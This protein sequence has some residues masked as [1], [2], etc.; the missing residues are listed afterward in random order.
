MDTIP[1]PRVDVQPDPATLST[2]VAGELLSRIADAQAAGG[3]PAVCLTGGTIAEEVHREIGRLGAASAVDWS[4]VDFWW[5]DERYVDLDSSDRNSRGAREAFLEPLGVPASRIHEMPT[6]SSAC[7]VDE[8]AKAYSAELRTKGS[9]EFLVTML[10]I[11]PDGH[12]ASLFPGFPQLHVDDQIAVGVTGSPKPPPERV[13]LTYPA[14][15]HSASVWF[16]VSG[17]GKADAVRRALADDGSIAE[18]PARGVQG[19]S[20]TIWFVDQ[21]AASQI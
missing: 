7:S 3:V 19:K 9:G 18:T 13:T 21:A 1:S 6:P 8:G 10:G 20:E 12:I 16:L 11:G 5:G 15:G 4:A 14:L 17:E 2:A